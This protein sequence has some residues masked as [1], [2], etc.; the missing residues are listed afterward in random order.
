MFIVQLTDVLI[1]EYMVP[2]R[3]IKVYI[4]MRHA[5]KGTLYPLKLQYT[6]QGY[7]LRDGF[8]RYL[9]AKR[10]GLTEVTAEIWDGNLDDY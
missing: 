5:K 4:S 7:V 8:A 9:G 3:P 10:H 2:P 1:P 6:P